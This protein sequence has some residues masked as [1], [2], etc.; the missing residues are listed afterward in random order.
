MEHI[1]FI[2]GRVTAMPDEQRRCRY[3]HI[4]A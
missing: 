4:V 2:P 1:A 3:G